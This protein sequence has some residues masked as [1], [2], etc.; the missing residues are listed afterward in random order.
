MHLLA[1][2]LARGLALFVNMSEYG[3]EHEYEYKDRN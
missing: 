3:D 2:L 1:C